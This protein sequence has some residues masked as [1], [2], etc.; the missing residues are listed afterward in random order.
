MTTK[1]WEIEITEQEKIIRRH[2]R[3]HLE[4]LLGRE[5]HFPVDK[6]VEK[7]LE[8][9]LAKKEKN[10]KELKAEIREKLKKEMEEGLKKKTE[11]KTENKII[12]EIIDKKLNHD[13]IGNI[14]KWLNPILP[15]KPNSKGINLI[16]GTFPWSDTFEI[17]D[18]TQ[19]VAYYLNSTNIFWLIMWILFNDKFEKWWNPAIEVYFMIKDFLKGKDK[20]ISKEISK[21]ISKLQQKFVNGVGTI[22]IWDSMH[23]WYVKPKDSTDKSRICILPTSKDLIDEN[24]TI[25]KVLFNWKKNKLN[26]HV[27][28]EE[29]FWKIDYDFCSSTSG[30]SSLSFWLKL[31]N[32]AHHLSIKKEIINKNILSIIDNIVKE[33]EELDKKVKKE[34]DKKVKKELK[35]ELDKKEKFE[36]Q[37]YSIMTLFNVWCIVKNGECFNEDYVKKISDKLTIKTF[38]PYIDNYLTWESDEWSDEWS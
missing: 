20:G 32:W 11:E 37:L 36:K 28:L 34:L 35:K 8:K 23:I 3:R 13:N 25:K 27:M 30:A 21:E 12:N 24:I 17:F 10:R 29:T 2:L 14:R 15:K 19:G 33:K 1:K 7:E 9:E 22:W 38:K 4:K 31:Y 16:L 6:K 5:R 18:W 26:Q